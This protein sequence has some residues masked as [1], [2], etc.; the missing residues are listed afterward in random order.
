MHTPSEENYLKAIYK[1]SEN[2]NHP[3]LTNSI[4]ELMQTKA[5][6]V[7]DMLKKLSAKKLIHYKKYQGVALTLEGKQ[8]AISIL[9][10]HRLW[11]YFLVEK[12]KF[13]WD[14]V[15]EA[16]EELEHINSQMLTDRLDEFLNFPRFDPHGDPI[17]DKNGKIFSNNYVAL[18]DLKIN[19]KGKVGGVGEQHTAF[20][21]HLGKLNINLGTAIQL[22]E[23][24]EFDKSVSVSIDKKPAI[25]LSYEVSK[26]ILMSI[27]KI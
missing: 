21:K 27:E 12:L 22:K 17:P 16:A 23:I 9:R 24:H 19:D 2:K 15:H 8:K 1:L 18:S 4:A 7:T 25:T 3:V 14:E 11:E 26:N 20:L 10:K 6:S 13:N 5:A